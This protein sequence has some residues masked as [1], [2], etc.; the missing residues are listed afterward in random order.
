MSLPKNER[1]DMLGLRTTKK[2][3]SKRQQNAAAAAAAA[4]AAQSSAAANAAATGVSSYQ[5]LPQISPATMPE[6]RPGVFTP[7]SCE[8]GSIPSQ[9]TLKAK[10]T[11][12]SIEEGLLGIS[13]QAVQTALI[14]L[15]VTPFFWPPLVPL[16][17][18][19]CA[20]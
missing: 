2:G 1:A 11:T 20:Q 5:P 17:A 16:L 6:Y 4:A 15:E 7:S 8:S 3:L 13:D 12:I 9:L 19:M 10:M 18:L 14:G